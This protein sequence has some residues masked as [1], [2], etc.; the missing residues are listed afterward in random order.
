MWDKGRVGEVGNKTSG[1]F[2]DII[3]HWFPFGTG[4]NASFCFA[5]N[6]SDGPTA[7]ISDD[8]Y[9]YPRS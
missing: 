3:F 1:N 6:V 7:L 4:D 8:P 9:T 5:I 2:C